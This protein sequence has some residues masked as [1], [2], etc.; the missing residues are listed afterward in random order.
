MLLVSLFTLLCT[1]NPLE[2]ILNFFGYWFGRAGSLLLLLMSC[3][4]LLCIYSL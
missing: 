4:W 1:F 2:G 3:V